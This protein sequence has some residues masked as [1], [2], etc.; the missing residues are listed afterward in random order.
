[1]LYLDSYIPTYLH[2][3]HT[4]VPNKNNK[5]IELSYDTLGKPR[6]LAQDSGHVLGMSLPNLTNSG[7][8]NEDIRPKTFRI[9]CVVEDRASRR[10][11]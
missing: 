11:L 2:I 10:A 8:H 9:A 4:D 7:S 6:R 5:E 3:G 1:M